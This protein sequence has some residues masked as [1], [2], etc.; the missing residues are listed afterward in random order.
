MIRSIPDRPLEVT[1]SLSS[2]NNS[3]ATDNRSKVMDNNNS[4][5]V[6]VRP[7]QRLRDRQAIRRIRTHSLE[8]PAECQACIRDNRG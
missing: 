4:S 1:D 6:T 5:R 3:R 2:N 8:C 7:V